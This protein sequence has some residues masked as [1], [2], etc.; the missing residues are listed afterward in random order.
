VS[1]PVSIDFPKLL[2]PQET[3]ERLLVSPA[4]LAI[5]RCTKRYPLPWVK[6]GRAVR[7]R[8]SDVR[9]FIEEGVTR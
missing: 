8:E 2:T 7:Y 9:K 3:A 1:A 5:W 6:V 4:T